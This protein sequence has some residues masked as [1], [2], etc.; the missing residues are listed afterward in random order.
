MCLSVKR[1]S[2][3]STKPGERPAARQCLG[4]LL[5]RRFEAEAR[6]TEAVLAHGRPCCGGACGRHSAAGGAAEGGDAKGGSVDLPMVSV[7][8]PIF[9]QQKPVRSTDAEGKKPG[10]DQIRTCSQTPG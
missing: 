6:A 5:E 2:R 1:D 3:A 8:N 10:A 9:T 4:G 7:G